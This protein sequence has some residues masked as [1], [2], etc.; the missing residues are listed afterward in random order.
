MTDETRDR[1]RSLQDRWLALP[2]V[3]KFRHREGTQTPV[4]SGG[5][6][7]DEVR[8]TVLESWEWYFAQ[9]FE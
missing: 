5:P 6:T 8:T 7:L 1:L 4:T 2:V 9:Y 3:E